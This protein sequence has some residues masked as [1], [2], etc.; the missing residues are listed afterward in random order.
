MD[1][2]LRSLFNKHLPTVDGQSVETAMTGG[3]V[4][5]WN[6]CVDGREG[7]VEMKKTDGW[8]VEV[9]AD[10]VGWIERRVRHGGRV[11]VAVRR[12]LAAGPRRGPAVDELWLFHGRAIRSIKERGLVAPYPPDHFGT[13]GGG[14]AAWDWDAVLRAMKD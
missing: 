6:Y 12:K 1:G 14:P 7:W 11:L 10:Q 2:G 5:D 13:W 8:A 9:R 4:P 3:G